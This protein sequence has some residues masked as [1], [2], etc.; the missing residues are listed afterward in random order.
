MNGG[1][2]IMLS[3]GPDIIPLALCSH[4]SSRVGSGYP[5]IDWEDRV[6]W[7]RGGPWKVLGGHVPEAVAEPV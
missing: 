5:L 1:E 7:P 3:L 2:E 4:G 6:V